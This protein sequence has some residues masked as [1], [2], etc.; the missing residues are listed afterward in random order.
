LEFLL[1]F[2]NDQV[3]YGKLAKVATMLYG[4]DALYFTNLALEGAHSTLYCTKMERFW[5]ENVN[6]FWR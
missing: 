2:I 5:L 6:N 4:V 3:D 1:E